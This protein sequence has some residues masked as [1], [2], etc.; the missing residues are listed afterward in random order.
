MVNSTADISEI[1]QNYF[2][3]MKILHP[4]VNTSPTSPS[5]DVY[6]QIQQA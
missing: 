6:L 2:E 5:M 1:R 4:L 3:I